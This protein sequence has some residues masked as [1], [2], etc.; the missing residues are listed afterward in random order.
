MSGILI[1][2]LVVLLLFPLLWLVYQLRRY[3]SLR[4][5]GFF[6]SR[7]GRDSFLYE[8]RRAGETQRLTIHGEMMAYGP[9][10]VYVPNEEEWEKETPEWAHGR[11]AEILENVKRALGTKN[12]E[13]DMS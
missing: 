8:E 4:F 3:F 2:V 11:H 13:Y 12:Y 10:V 5:R 7:E 6:V 1:L 9:H